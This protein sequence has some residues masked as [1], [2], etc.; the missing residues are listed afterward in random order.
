MVDQ[1]LEKEVNLL[2]Q[3]ICY[4]LADPKRVLILYAL[5]EKPLRVNDLASAL[6]AP[7]STVSRH[8]RVLRERG[9][10]VTEREGTYIIYSLADTR[11]I[12]A[13]DLLRQVLVSQLIAETAGAD[14]YQLPSERVAVATHGEDLEAC[15]SPK[16][17]P[18]TSFVIVDAE[19][20]R[21]EVVKVEPSESFEQASVNA[22]RAAARNG[23]TVV[24]TPGIRPECCVALRALGIGVIIADE[25]LTVREAMEKFRRGELEPASFL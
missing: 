12:E 16:D 11:L 24:I 1:R 6:D 7:Q 13:V 8:L 3:R 17:E 19:T 25:E 4:A 15:L 5:S 21:I 10:V 22:V 20:M 2:H 18:C 23:A 9:L 14:E